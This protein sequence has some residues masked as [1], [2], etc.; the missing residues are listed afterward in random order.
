[1]E[2]PHRDHLGDGEGEPLVTPGVE[3]PRTGSGVIRCSIDAAQP[4]AAPAGGRPQ[5]SPAASAAAVAAL[6]FDAGVGR[7]LERL[8]GDHQRQGLAPLR[9]RQ[10][11]PRLCVAIA[12][13]P[14]RCRCC[15]YDWSVIDE[16][17]K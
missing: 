8:V 5:A 17:G 16:T 10:D 9:G 4:A 6:Q 12:P 13:L 2:G 14:P 15:C 3:G 7:I 1:M 11:L